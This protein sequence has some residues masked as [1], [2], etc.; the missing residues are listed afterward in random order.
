LIQIYLAC[1]N[2]IIFPGSSKQANKIALSV[3]EQISNIG[4]SM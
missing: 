1:F 4:K 3:Y 2:L